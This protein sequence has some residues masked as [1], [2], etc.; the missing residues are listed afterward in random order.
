MSSTYCA[1]TPGSCLY[2]LYLFLFIYLAPFFS[3]IPSTTI[4]KGLASTSF[5]NVMTSTVLRWP[6]RERRTAHKFV[7]NISSSASRSWSRRISAIRIFL[8]IPIHTEFW[9][10]KIKKII[11][12]SRWPILSVVFCSTCSVSVFQRIYIK[13]SKLEIFWF[14]PLIYASLLEPICT[15]S[16]RIHFQK[17]KTCFIIR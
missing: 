8:K 3:Y 14:R 1:V 9:F 16:P 4:D 10:E 5:M 17:H 7:I 13:I 2:R 12:H 15:S 11:S 6:C